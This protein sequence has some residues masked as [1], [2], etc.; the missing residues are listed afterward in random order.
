LDWGVHGGIIKL[1]FII[2]RGELKRLGCLAHEP[3]GVYLGLKDV[4]FGS[5]AAYIHGRARVITTWT[6][7]G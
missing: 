4:D 1:I 2:E 7:A 5:T 6:S 3:G